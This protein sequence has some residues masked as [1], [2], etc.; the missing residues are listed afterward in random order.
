MK[1]VKCE[2]CGSG[3]LVLNGGFFVCQACGTKYS[4]EEVKKMMI[5]GTVD[6]QGTVKVDNSSFVEKYLHN[7]RRSKIKEDW[8]ET[9]KYYN[10]VEQNDPT[11]IEAIFYSAY[12]KA[13][14]SLLDTDIFK[15]KAFKVLQNC[16]SIIDDNFSMQKEESDSKMIEQIVEDL[17]RLICHNF[18]YKEAD[19]G[20]ER[21][22]GIFFMLLSESVITIENIIKKYGEDKKKAKYLYLQIIKLKESIRDKIYIKHESRVEYHKEVVELYNKVKEI[23]PEFI[24]PHD[25]IAKGEETIR[26]KKKAENFGKRMALIVAGIFVGAAGITL[27]ICAI[28]GYI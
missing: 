28:L 22:Q 1:V 25:K 18:I 15:R 19:N 6:V 11:N 23:D 16:V 13:M 5:E 27:L 26:L 3:E 9:E 4:K 24:I 7:A 2:M 14:A 12:A 10:M 8:T 17:I 21:T 20:W